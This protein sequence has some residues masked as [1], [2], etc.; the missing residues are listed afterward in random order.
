MNIVECNHTN[1]PYNLP[2]R[3]SSTADSELLLKEAVLLNRGCHLSTFSFISSDNMHLA[4]QLP[5][6][7]DVT[8]HTGCMSVHGVLPLTAFEIVL[9]HDMSCIYDC[10]TLCVVHTPSRGM[11]WVQ[12]QQGTVTRVGRKHTNIGSLYKKSRRWRVEERHRFI[13][14][15]AGTGYKEQFQQV[16]TPHTCA[17]NYRAVT[18]VMSF[19]SHVSSRLSCRDRPNTALYAE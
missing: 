12:R 18:Y 6:T 15:D 14:S 17:D 3:F 9:T 10:V 4:G 1:L 7:A 11:L 13:S 8:Y 19:P 5:G 2:Y 16:C